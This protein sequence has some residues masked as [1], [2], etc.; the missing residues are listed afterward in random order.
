MDQGQGGQGDLNWRLSAHPITLLVF[1]GIRIGL[2]S[3]TPSNSNKN[4]LTNLVVRCATDVSIWCT[5]HRWLVRTLR[6]TTCLSTCD[7]NVY[8]VSSSSFSPFFSSPRISTTSKTLRDAGWSAYVGGTRSTPRPATP[9]G[10]SNHPTPTSALWQPLTSGSSGWACMSHQ[11]CGWVL[12]YWLLWDLSVL[13]GSVW[14]VSYSHTTLIYFGTRYW[15]RFSYCTYLDYHEY[16][17]LL[18]LW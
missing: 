11:L 1:L 12:R 8:L 18:S 15:L 10:S 17:G 14:L 4:D 5:L 7:A 16:H 9:S 13:F 2:Y 3:P 6:W